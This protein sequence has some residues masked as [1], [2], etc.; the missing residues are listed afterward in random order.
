[1]PHKTDFQNALIRIDELYPAPQVMA[2]AV[3]MMRNPDLEASDL[4]NLLKTDASLTADIIRLSNSAYYG[5]ATEC[6]NLTAAVSRVGF[7]EVLRLLNLSISK[8]VLAKDLDAYGITAYDYWTTCAS[9]AI[10]MES[11][12]QVT[13]EDPNDAY[14]IGVLHLIGRVLINQL[15]NDFGFSLFWDG[16]QDLSEWEVESVGFTSAYAGSILLKRWNFPN[17]TCGVILNQL[18]PDRLPNQPE[19]LKALHFATEL[20][21]QTGPGFV[22]DKWEVPENHPFLISSRISMSQIEEIIK[23]GKTEFAKLKDSLNIEEEKYN[24]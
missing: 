13:G 2:K 20:L 10:L 19:L 15:L 4:V 9:I 22:N 3:H 1:M 6:K 16:E 23:N 8:S 21:K 5:F 12:A 18:N 14:T 17:E 24:D 11:F 7:Y